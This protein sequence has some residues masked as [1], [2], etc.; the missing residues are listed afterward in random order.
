L[1]R[2]II[3]RF[4]ARGTPTETITV[5]AGAPTGTVSVEVSATGQPRFTIHENVA[6][7]RLEASAGARVAVERAD[8]ICFGT[9]AQRTKPASEAVNALLAAARPEALRVFDINLR[10][11][12]VDPDVIARSL[13]AANVLKLNEQEL[14]VLAKFFDLAGEPA[15]QI[16]TL[17]DRFSLRLVA[18]TRGGDGSLLFSQGEVLDQAGTPT[19][20]R[21]TIG[22]GDSFTAALVAGFLRGWPLEQISRHAN[23]IAAFVCSQPGATP[24]LPEALRAP[25][26]ASGHGANIPHPVL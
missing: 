15:R 12:F 6:W 8:A 1:G 14:P 21:D 22:A 9:L 10:P 3:A 23:A 20:V 19:I 7:D 26:A 2:E 16:A 18:L 4:A 24:P 25:F 13:A 17:A 11:P 5:D